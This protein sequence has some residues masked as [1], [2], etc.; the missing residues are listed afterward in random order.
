MQGTDIVDIIYTTVCKKLSIPYLNKHILT[1][2]HTIITITANITFFV[3]HVCENLPPGASVHQNQ[4]QDLFSFWLP[5]G[6]FWRE[7]Y[8]RVPLSCK[9]MYTGDT[10][11]GLLYIFQSNIL[12]SMFS[13]EYFTT[14][15]YY[16]VLFKALNN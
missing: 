14:G 1:K 10:I 3:I 5:E 15:Q 7:P 9:C 13:V 2:I 12:K 4:D 11:S 6:I 8:S 16:T